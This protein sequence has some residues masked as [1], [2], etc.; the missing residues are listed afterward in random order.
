MRPSL[1]TRMAPGRS[2]L[3]DEIRRRERPHRL[4]SHELKP[5]DAIR[6]RTDSALLAAVRLIPL[7]ARERAALRTP[8]RGHLAARRRWA[9]Q[10]LLP[11]DAL[12]GQLSV[13]HPFHR[14][15]VYGLRAF[16]KRPIVNPTC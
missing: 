10:T 15:R 8:S 1:P 2:D 16:E 6:R 3:R 4:I 7:A 11:F 14:L 5:V 13:V 12:Y 9:R